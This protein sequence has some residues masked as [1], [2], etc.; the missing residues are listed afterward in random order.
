M[1]L[2]KKTAHGAFGTGGETYEN[3]SVLQN[4]KLESG[5]LL[6]SLRERF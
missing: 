6:H 3:L 1:R 2:R 5:E 4:G